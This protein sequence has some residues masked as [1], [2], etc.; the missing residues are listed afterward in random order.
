PDK[1]D[2]AR[3]TLKTWLCMVARCKAI[4]RY[5]T[6]SRHSTVPLESAMM[7]GRMGIQDALLQEETKR[8]LVA[9]VNALADVEK[10]ILIRRY[11][12][13]QKPREIAKALDMPVKQV[14]NHL[15]RSKQK[16]RKAITVC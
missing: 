15:Y 12:Y 7:A 2:A 9:A 10:D 5:R 1:Y 16:L 8:E 14:E 11:Y 4:D 6:L 3:G 13:E